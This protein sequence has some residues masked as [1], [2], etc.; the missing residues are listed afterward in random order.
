MRLHIV[1]AAT[2]SWEEWFGLLEDFVKREKHARVHDDYTTADGAALGKWVGK[3]RAAHN[4][5]T[6]DLEHVKR[7]ERVRGWI[8]DPY[9]LDWERNFAL[10]KKFVRR[11]G[12]PRV[13]QAFVTADG[14][15][16]GGWVSVQRVARSRGTLSAERSKRLEEI[17]GW[18]WDPA[19]AD[20]ERNFAL[21]KAFVRRKGNARVPLNHVTEDGTA[22]GVWVRIQRAART[23]GQLPSE[24][25]D[26]LEA[27]KGWTWDPISQRW[28]DNFAELEAFV[29]REKHARVPRDYA[30]ADGTALGSWVTT[31][32]IFRRNG[33]LNPARARRLEYLNGW[34]W[35]PRSQ[36][37]Q[38]NYAL[39]KI[40]AEERGH[41]RVPQTHRA[42]DGTRLGAWV[43][44]QRNDHRRGKLG[45]ERIHRLQ[46]LPG[47]TWDRRAHD[48]DESF[49]SLR[50]LVGHEGHARVPQGMKTT[51]GTD[52]SAWI[53]N[54]RLAR[55]KGTLSTERISQLEK[56]R[57]W[58]WDPFAEAW[59][60][61]FAFLR[62][63]IKRTGHSRV[64]AAY[65]TADGTAL[66]NWVSLQRVAH[67]R[68]TLTPDRTKRLEK[69]RG[70]V[71]SVRAGTK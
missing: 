55:D 62:D 11:E 30:T 63:F 70:W 2:A 28:E 18:T 15:K 35:D 53:S 24:R 50:S 69:L 22:L 20:W 10:L 14:T 46:A 31:Q 45:P 60:R 13:P 26:R 71:W 48:W 40:F 36:D 5:G 38:E 3:Q 59:E 39:L 29:K 21:V 66:G 25:S 4:R 43:S 52:L 34:T 6:L 17:D 32:R 61:N 67:R 16:L 44:A 41:A 58:T 27:L 65:M 64:P 54:Q 47:W 23:A 9:A 51:A 33:K 8:W 12:N 19:A 49:A 56:L 68:A 57:S 42:A 37:W 7:L 1:E